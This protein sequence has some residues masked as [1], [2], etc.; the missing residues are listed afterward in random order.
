MFFDIFGQGPDVSVHD[1]QKGFSLKPVENTEVKE[2]SITDIIKKPFMPSSW[3][4]FSTRRR[5]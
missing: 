5:G 4:W 2:A 3:N 1:I